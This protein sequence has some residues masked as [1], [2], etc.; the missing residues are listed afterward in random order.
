MESDPALLDERSIG[1]TKDE[2]CHRKHDGYL[3]LCPPRLRKEQAGR[4]QRMGREQEERAVAEERARGN[5]ATPSARTSAMSANPR[6]AATVGRE[7]STMANPFAAEV[8]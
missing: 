8:E 7:E 1:A 6:P 4:E 3:N 2:G 5:G